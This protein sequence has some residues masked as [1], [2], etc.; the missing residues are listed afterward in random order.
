MIAVG[1]VLVTL[2]IMGFMVCR[3]VVMMLGIMGVVPIVLGV[4]VIPIGLRRL[5][6]VDCTFDDRALD[7]VV[8][9]APSRIAVTGTARWLERFSLSSSASRWGAL[10]SFDQRLTISNRDLII[11]RMNFAEGE[12]AV[13]VAAISMKGGL[14]GRFYPRDLGEIDVAA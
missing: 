5:R 8:A 6:G 4:L 13:A 1:S 9:A 7:A 12:E 14:E 11:V 2:V 3:R 10:V